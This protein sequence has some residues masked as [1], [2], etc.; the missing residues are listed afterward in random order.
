M[1]QCKATAIVAIKEFPEGVALG[2]SFVNREQER[3]HLRQR[4]KSVQHT[5]LIAPRRYGKTS[6]VLKVAE[7]L[8]LPHRAL[9]LFAAYNEEYVRD[10]ITDKVSTLV[11]ELL[12]R[13]EKAK[14]K[15]FNIFKAMKPEISL[16]GFG[17]RLNLH[18]NGNP[19]QDITSL[20]LKLDETAKTFNKQVVI[21]LDEFQQISELK[22]YHSIEASI[23]HAV[24][25]SQ[26]V[27]YVFSGSN[28]HMLQQ[29][30]GDKG[31]PLYRLCQTM[32]LGRIHSDHYAPRLLQ[33][34][35]KQWGK[36]LDAEIIQAIFDLT[37]CHPFYMNAFCQIIW[38]QKKQPKNIEALEELWS[39]YIKQQRYN[40]SLDVMKLSPNQRKV[41]VALAQKPE[42]EVQAAEFI[43]KLKISASSSQQSISVLLKKDFI[44]HHEIGYT[45]IDPAVKYYLNN[46]L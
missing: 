25:R 3:Q 17:Q 32:E 23:R 33:L 46:F 1:T 26:N 21:F 28:R 10:Q 18:L 15:V 40:V 14:E 7:E 39:T 4:I 29:M 42:H 27:S 8:K 35:K 31:R 30:F 16:G 45:L 2:S 11:I 41:L 12:P 44:M 9:D 24:E 22:N 19:L 34:S 43:A 6:L 37:E 5:V 13:L 36:E 20:L 38:E